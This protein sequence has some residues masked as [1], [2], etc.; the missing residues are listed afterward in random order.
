MEKVQL[1]IWGKLKII[2][3]A[4]FAPHQTAVTTLV[5]NVAT[6][7]VLAGLVVPLVVQ[8]EHNNKKK[9]FGTSS[10]TKQSKA[11]D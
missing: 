4:T 6:S 7:T 1:Y 3:L 10:K 11:M 5:P 8:E 9:I 2:F